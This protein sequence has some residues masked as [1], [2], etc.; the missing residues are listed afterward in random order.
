VW[1]CTFAYYLFIIWRPWQFNRK[2]KN[3]GF[4]NDIF[5]KRMGNLSYLY[6]CHL[7]RFMKINWSWKR[8]GEAKSSKQP[9]KDI[10]KSKNKV[11]QERRRLDSVKIWINED[12]VERGE[13]KRGKKKGRVIKEESVQKNIKKHVNCFLQREVRLKMLI[14]LTCLWF[15]L[16]IRRH[17][18]TLMT[19]IIVLLLF[20]FLITR[21]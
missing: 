9:Y 20:C 15:Y 1:C 13:N 19:L 8:K 18:L 6:H 7:D 4:K 10:R 11:S 17:I 16:Y 2:A 12:L 3:D 21:F 5:L 14:F